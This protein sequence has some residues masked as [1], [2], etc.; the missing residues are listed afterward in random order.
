[1]MET[2]AV[3]YT[4]A[5]GLGLDAPQ[6]LGMDQDGVEALVIVLPLI[7]VGLAVIGFFVGREVGKK[8]E[9]GKGKKGTTAQAG[10]QA[11]PGQAGANG[12]LVAAQNDGHA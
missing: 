6:V 4:S 12:P 10:A 1:M 9:K 11:D 3:T 8:R 7:A 5:S 2:A